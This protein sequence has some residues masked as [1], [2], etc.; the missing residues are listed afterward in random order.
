M[1]KIV[2][3]II[4]FVF[5]LSSFSSAFAQ[6]DY[7][8]NKQAIPGQAKTSDPVEYI[9]GLYKF[10]VGAAI[11]LGLFMVGVGGFIYM[12]GAA[13]NVAKMGDAKTMII[14]AIVGLVIALIAYLILFVINPDLIQGT[15]EM[16]GVPNLKN[17]SV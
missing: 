1:K 14:D 15:I 11:F 3:T 9:N 8:E 16:K 7:Y 17:L 12:T 5:I 13:G 6:S 10:G 4:I 2:P